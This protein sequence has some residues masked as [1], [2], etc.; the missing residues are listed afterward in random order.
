[1]KFALQGIVAMLFLLLFTFCAWYEGSEILDNHWEW[2][3]ST[4]FSEKVDDTT[5][6]SNLDYFVYAAK[7][8]PMFPAL[9]MGTLLYLIMLTGLRVCKGS[10]TRKTF[11]LTG[12]GM[13]VLLLS[14]LVWNSPTVGGNLFKGMCLII[15]WVSILIGA[16]YYFKIPIIFKKAG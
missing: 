14:G 13:L 10:D 5:D 11:F 7:F 3:Y 4:P 8:R 6:I 12:L 16:L 9:M 1:M 2:K 15:G